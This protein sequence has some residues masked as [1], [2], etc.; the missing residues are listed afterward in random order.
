MTTTR[1]SRHTAARFSAAMMLASLSGV[2]CG[3]GS[4]ATGPEDQDC[5][6]V[7]NSLISYPFDGNAND[8]SGNANH[9]TVMGATLASDRFGNPARA[10]AFDGVDDAISIG[11]RGQAPFP[12]SVSLWFNADEL[13][14]AQIFSNDDTN[15]AA[16]RWGIGM[17]VDA[18]GTVGANI[19]EGFSAPWNRVSYYAAATS[20]YVP[21]EWHHVGIVFN[22]SRSAVIYFDGDEFPGVYSGTGSGLVYGG[23][24]GLIGRMHGNSIPKFQFRGRLDDIQVF[25]QALTAADV[26]A[27]FEMP[28]GCI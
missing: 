15:D 6:T 11:P 27:L 25:G 19:Y 4:G 12:F 2:S 8:A 5:P 13:R 18:T 14:F 9:G 16:N 17:L 20:L 26:E 28:D 10:Y 21:G 24:N 23:G 7:P 22:G 1:I 3:E